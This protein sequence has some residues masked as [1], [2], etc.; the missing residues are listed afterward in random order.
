MYK[1]M[2]HTLFA[3]PTMKCDNI[4][5]NYFASAKRFAT[6]SQLTTFQNDAM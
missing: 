3:W 1:N 2:G 6:A 5:I 4:S